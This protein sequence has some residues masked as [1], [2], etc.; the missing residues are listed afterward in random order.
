M[1]KKDSEILIPDEVIMNKIYL[2]RGKKVMLDRDLGQL[3]NVETKQLKRAVR[4][5]IRR[6]PEDFMFELSKEELDKWRCQFGASNKEIMG[7][8][9]SPFAFTEYGVI[10]LASVLNS[11]RAILVNI[12]VVRIFNKM[13]EWKVA[14]F[15]QLFYAGVI[16]IIDLHSPWLYYKCPLSENVICQNQSF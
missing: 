9:V 12:Q 14:S 10:M 6:F 8:R 2:I 15:G 7:L 1:A 16:G 13:R 11:D 4:R 5:N 3:Y